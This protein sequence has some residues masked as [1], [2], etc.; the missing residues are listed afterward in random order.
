MALVGDEGSASHPSHFTPKERA[1]G[2]HR[3]GWLGPK[4]GVDDMKRIKIIPLLG[5]D[6][7]PV[8][9]CYTISAI[10]VLL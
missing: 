2:A 10:L 1:P 5:F 4:T 7:Q 8:A 6:L 3:I 9:S